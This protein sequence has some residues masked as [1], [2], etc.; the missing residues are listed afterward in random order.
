[1]APP[2]RKHTGKIPQIFRKM[3]GTDGGNRK[4][5]LLVLINSN[6]FFMGVRHFV[7]FCLVSFYGCQRK[8]PLF[9][10]TLRSGGTFLFKF[11][12]EN[13][14]LQ[15]S[16]LILWWVSHSEAQNILLVLNW[17]LRPPDVV[18][19]VLWTGINFTGQE[20]LGYLSFL[21]CSLINFQCYVSTCYVACFRL[22]EICHGFILSIKMNQ[23]IYSNEYFTKN[24]YLIIIFQN[25]IQYDFLGLDS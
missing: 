21:F 2:R 12:R 17:Q 24:K 4:C 22:L 23:V 7:R 11:Y 9:S 19:I 18:W 6:L 14:V 20:L 15:Q 1:M 8:W 10:P 16:L 25:K 5:F 13:I 3:E